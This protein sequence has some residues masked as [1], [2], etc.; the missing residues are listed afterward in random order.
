MFEPQRR[1]DDKQWKQKDEKTPMYC[2]ENHK[3]EKD[4]C[5]QLS[6]IQVGQSF[7][8]FVHLIIQSLA[9]ST[10]ILY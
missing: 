4:V 6:L 8:C 1:A 2:Q 3:F 9:D 10:K 5:M 7:K